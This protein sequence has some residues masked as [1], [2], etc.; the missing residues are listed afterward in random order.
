MLVPLLHNNSSRVGKKTTVSGTSWIVT[1]DLGRCQQWNP[2]DWFKSAFI[3]QNMIT[4]KLGYLNK[5]LR[6]QISSCPKAGNDWQES[7]MRGRCEPCV[8]LETAESK[9]SVREDR[10]Q[11]WE[12]GGRRREPLTDRHNWPAPIS[13]CKDN[14]RLIPENMSANLR[15]YYLYNMLWY[16]VNSNI[17]N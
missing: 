12:G 6:N 10:D 8:R 15:G 3:C 1:T 4:K 2:G 11:S 13:S 9:L 7:N 5:K 14:L 16:Y 17:S